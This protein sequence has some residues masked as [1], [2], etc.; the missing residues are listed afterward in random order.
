MQDFIA[1]KDTVTLIGLLLLYYILEEF[2]VSLCNN[3]PTYNIGR[4]AV[5]QSILHSMA[6]LY[7]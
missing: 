3:A 6:F 2:C 4:H 7:V 5:I 1:A